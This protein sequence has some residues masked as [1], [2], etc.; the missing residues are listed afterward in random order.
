MK[1]LLHM[2][3]KPSVLVK[4]SRRKNVK[5]SGMML[6]LGQGSLHKEFGRLPSR[7][8][9]FNLGRLKY[10]STSPKGLKV[11]DPHKYSTLP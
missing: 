10:S 6:G 2:Y 5:M 3:F 7:K 8:T 11:Y 4:M 9:F 1:E